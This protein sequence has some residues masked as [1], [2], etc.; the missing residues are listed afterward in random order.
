[1]IQ[2]SAAGAVGIRNQTFTG[3]S[4]IMVRYPATTKG[5]VM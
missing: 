1:M 4:C 2:C 5:L 3:P